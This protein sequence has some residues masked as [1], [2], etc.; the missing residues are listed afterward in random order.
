MAKK[1]SHS[2]SF[3][4][5]LKNHDIDLVHANSL[6]ADL[7]G[8]T[9][10]RLARK[11][12]IWH[13]RDRISSDYLPASVCRSFR[14]LAR[15]LP[16]Q[17]VAN[18]NA[19]LASLRLGHSA[20]GPLSKRHAVVHDGILVN[21][22]VPPTPTSPRAR[23]GP[24]MGL[25]GRITRWKGQHIFI[26]TAAE[27]NKRF[28]NARFLIIGSALFGEDAYEREV[29]DLADSLGLQDVVEFTGYREDVD[30]AIADLD[31]LVHAS[32]TGEPFGQVIIE[33][34]AAGK[35]VVA[36]AGGGV[37]EIVVDGVTGSLVPMGDAN[38]MAAAI[39][40]MLEQPERS[41]EMGRA[42]RRRVLDHFTIEQTARKIEAI[43]EILLN[44][45]KSPVPVEP[46]L[47][48]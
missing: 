41:L 29:R 44:P 11:P 10:A 47:A 48:R 24:L 1:A 35:P 40:S 17:I 31:I 43:Y 3:C 9:A 21:E 37:L 19:T 46:A 5:V 39:I 7:I 23:D 8:G 12:V 34:M 18:S 4:P 42:G 30:R 33:G 36:T 15:F 27:V 38:A 13:V 20:G 45:S 25:V 28:P 2:V 22:V 16:T 6:K 32:T 26:Q 14:L